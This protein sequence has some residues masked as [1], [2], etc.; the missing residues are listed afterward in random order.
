MDRAIYDYIEKDYKAIYELYKDP[1]DI[2]QQKVALFKTYINYKEELSTFFFQLGGCFAISIDPGVCNNPSCE[3]CCKE[4][5]YDY[6]LTIVNHY[7]SIK[8]GVIL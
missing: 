7:P 5:M 1:K 4:K 2:N 3:V 8:A 6:L